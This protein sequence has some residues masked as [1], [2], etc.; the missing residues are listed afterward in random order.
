MDGEI[1]NWIDGSMYRQIG[2][3]IDRQIDRQIDRTV[4]R[5]NSQVFYW[6]SFLK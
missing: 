3:R 4:E 1:G 5:D 6:I 2:G